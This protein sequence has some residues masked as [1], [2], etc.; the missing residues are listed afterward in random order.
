MSRLVHPG[1]TLLQMVERQ[2]AAPP[3][4]TYTNV[5]KWL[6]KSITLPS[7]LGRTLP[8]FLMLYYI[9]IKIYQVQIDFAAYL[10]IN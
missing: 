8:S 4:T 5:L 10:F 1:I 3:L 2:S 7:F 9:N 6:D